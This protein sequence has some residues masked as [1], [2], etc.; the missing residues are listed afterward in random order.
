M[1]LAVIL[2]VTFSAAVLVL[3]NSVQ[4]GLERLDQASRHEVDLA[5]SSLDPQSPLPADLI[6]RIQRLDLAIEEI[7]GFVESPASLFMTTADGQAVEREALVIISSSWADQSSLNAYVVLEGHPPRADQEIVL[8]VATAQDY[9]LK[10][11]DSIEIESLIRSGARSF[12]LVGLADLKASV[13]GQIDQGFIRFN[14]FSQ[15]EAQRLFLDEVDGQQLTTIKIDLDLER[16]D[17]DFA[18]SEITSV[19]PKGAVVQAGA[20]LADGQ[21]FNQQFNQTM[22]KSISVFLL[23][24]IALAMLVGLSV[25]VNTFNVLLAQRA[26]ELALLRALAFSKGQIRKLVIIEAF[27][28]GCSAAVVGVAL[29]IAL[30]SIV[31]K[32]IPAAG[33]ALPVTQ[34]ILSLGVFLYPALL[35]VSV[36]VLAALWPA[37]RASRLSPVAVLTETAVLKSRSLRKRLIVGLAVLLLEILLISAILTGVFSRPDIL[38]SSE[39]LA[40]SIGILTGCLLITVGVIAL[41]PILIRGLSRLFGRCLKFLGVSLFL[42]AGNVWRQARRSGAAANALMIGLTL[43]VII[44]TLI[45]SMQTTVHRLIDEIQPADWSVVL[46]FEKLNFSE[47]EEAERYNLVPVQLVEEIDQLPQ[48]TNVTPVRYHYGAID[49]RS[50]DDEAVEDAVLHLAAVRSDHLDQTLKL[51]LDDAEV[52]NLKAGQLLVHQTIYE[53]YGLKAGQELEVRFNDAPPASYII[54]GS[55]DVYFDGMAFL[56]EADD[57]PPGLSD[58]Y[59]T[60]ILFDSAPGVEDEDLEPLLEDLLKDYPSLTAF[61]KTHITEFVDQMFGVVLNIF[62]AS[63]SLSLVVAFIG[64]FNILS[65]SIIERRKEL[66]VLRALGMTRRQVKKMV[67]WEAVIMVTFSVL[68]GFVLGL[69]F[70]WLGFQMITSPQVLRVENLGFDFVFNIPWLQLLLYSLIALVVALAAAYWP[71][72]RAARQNIIEGLAS[73]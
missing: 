29:G 35:G 25:I 46:D 1:A 38:P 28:I 10:L 4:A 59:A 23:V 40:A 3:S 24:F 67:S 36:T 64:I 42:A 63:L 65:L 70:A 44:T 58:G 22:V 47:R 41:S 60:Y 54:G 17:L 43:I 62:R 52:D 9:D 20:D 39:V 68:S 2:G 27:L 30:G 57:A 72:R 73:R 16:T 15:A 66:A 48:T 45:S 37:W 53:E 7:A 19:L 21:D 13:N 33:L 11:G 50:L 14:L 12:E 18:K 71:A 32:L 6:E 34:P 8:D 26:K 55:F 31:L 61:G 69:A 56:L 5:V 51:G 49:A